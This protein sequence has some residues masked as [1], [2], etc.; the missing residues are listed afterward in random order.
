MP[1]TSLLIFIAIT[2]FWNDQHWYFWFGVEGADQQKSGLKK[3]YKNFHNFVRE[4]IKIKT[5]YLLKDLIECKKIGKIESHFNES[6]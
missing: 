4:L 2:Q 5:K 6:Y 3:I 1:I